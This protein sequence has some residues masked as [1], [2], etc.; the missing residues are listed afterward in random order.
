MN[1]LAYANPS[2]THIFHTFLVH[3]ETMDQDETFDMI[4]Q[5]RAVLDDDEFN[6]SPRY[7]S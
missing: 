4:Y 6:S 3:T 5:W 7:C 2:A 1:L